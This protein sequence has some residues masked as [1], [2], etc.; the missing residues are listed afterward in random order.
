[1]SDLKVSLKSFKGK[2]DE[3]MDYRFQLRAYLGIHEC[4][5]YLDGNAE[6]RAQ[7]PTEKQRRIYI[8]ISTSIE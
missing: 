7:I 2:A 6:K 4:T 3:Y 8:A 5:E 1:M